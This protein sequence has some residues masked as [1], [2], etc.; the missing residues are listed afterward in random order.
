MKKTSVVMVLFI[1][2]ALLL[3]FCGESQDS[4]S[5]NCKELCAKA[6]E[7]E[8]DDEAECNNFCSALNTK[9]YVQDSYIDAMNA[10]D[11]KKDCNEYEKCVSAAD[12][13]CKAVDI[14]GFVNTYCDKMVNE[15][16]LSGLTVEKC[17]E[18]IQ[19]DA[20]ASCITIKYYD[21][22]SACIKKADCASITDDSKFGEYLETCMG[23]I[24]K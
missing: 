22:L 17:K 21:D 6:K 3:I 4:K 13:G 11:T 5:L 15:C 19:G 12:D 2:S 10:C 20:D 16:K 14:S 8:E 7:C 1:I 9:G 24:I 18:E 23:I